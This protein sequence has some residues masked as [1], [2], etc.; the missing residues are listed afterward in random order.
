[1]SGSVADM[2]GHIQV[3]DKVVSIDG[4]STASLSPKTAMNGIDTSI[5]GHIIV[6]TKVEEDSSDTEAPPAPEA[7]PPQLPLTAP[8]GVPI[9]EMEAINRTPD[10]VIDNTEEAEAIDRTPDPVID[11]TEEVE[12]NIGIK[13]DSVMEDLRE[14]ETNGQEILDSE[15]EVIGITPDSMMVN[16]KETETSRQEILD[17]KVELLNE[18][19]DKVAKSSENLNESGAELDKLAI[20]ENNWT[21]DSLNVTIPS[22]LEVSSPQGSQDSGLGMPSPLDTQSSLEESTPTEKPKEDDGKVEQS[23]SNGDLNQG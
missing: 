15:V 16:S 6:L 12:A 2:E 23:I 20:N 19:K 7:P 11:N 14:S 10:S 3:G 9:E 21:T 8:P 22:N 18:N 5:S 1:M 4:V 13:P 17:S